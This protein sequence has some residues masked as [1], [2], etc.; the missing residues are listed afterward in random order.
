MKPIKKIKAG[1]LQFVLFIGVVIAVLL[2]AFMLLSHTHALF[3]KK[4]DVMVTVIKSAD[5]GLKMSL[6]KV[7]PLGDSIKVENENDVSIEIEVKRTLWGIFEKRTVRASHLHT[8]QVKTVLI[9]GK[10][11]NEMPALYVNDKRRPVIIA[12]DSKITGT[13]F[14][15][16]Q[17]LK[18]GNIYG[19]SY[20]QS[21]LLYGRRKFSDS[22]LP[23]L[24]AELETQIKLLTKPNFVPLGE[25]LTRIPDKIVRNSFQSPTLIIRD[26][27]IQLRDIQLVGNIIISASD[28]IIVESSANLQD[29]ILLAPKIV[30]KDWVKGHF[31]A[32]ASENIS[33]GKKC[34]LAY[35][36]AL[37]VNKKPNVIREEGTETKPI[38]NDQPRIYVDS[39]AEIRGVVLVLEEAKEQQFFPQIKIDD[40]AK[41]IGELYCTKNLELK[42]RVNGSV[43]TDAFIALENGS[44]YQ[45]H[46]Y[47]GI[48]N[49]TN[50]SKSYAGLFLRGRERNKK[51][52]KWLY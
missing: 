5:F 13:A 48:I 22:V 44:I 11:L 38:R 15:P 10:D 1:A 45:N 33:V 24:S 12:G 35:P 18:M 49:S 31:Q 51:V 34:E 28:K 14:L 36:T 46:L 37:V 25:V 21:R 20:N 27:K 8:V 29:V 19:N 50:L 17:G 32:I 23:R 9:G 42:G 16:E 41:V 3:D 26:R 6:D 47:N 52:M 2:M 43:S 39:Y 7:I 4:T 30:I 40:N